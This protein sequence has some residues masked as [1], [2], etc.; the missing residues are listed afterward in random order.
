MGPLITINA[1]ALVHEKSAPFRWIFC[2][3]TT[4]VLSLKQ[5][6]VG[7]R[8]NRKSPCIEE[9]TLKDEMPTKALELKKTN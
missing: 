7:G 9:E 3:I 1:C 4:G 5:D 2:P 6:V 8:C